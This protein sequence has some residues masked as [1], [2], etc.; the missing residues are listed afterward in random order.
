MGC[1]C[2]G[3]RNLLQGGVQTFRFAL[4]SFDPIIRPRAR[5]VGVQPLLG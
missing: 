1:G 2:G 3:I 5:Y 4:F